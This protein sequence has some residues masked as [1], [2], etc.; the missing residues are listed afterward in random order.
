MREYGI[1]QSV[2]RVEDQRLLTGKGNKQRVMPLADAASGD[3]PAAAPPM[4]S[5]V[6]SWNTMRRVGT[7]GRR[8]STRCQPI[9]SPSRSSSVA[10]KS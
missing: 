6:I 3:A 8:T 7:L 2:P 9:D 4:A 10:T 1:G 5:R